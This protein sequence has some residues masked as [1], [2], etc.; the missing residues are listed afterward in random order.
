MAGLNWPGLLKWSIAHSDGTSPSVKE[1]MSAERLQFLEA[2]MKEA[3]GEF[4]DPN[5]V[6]RKAVKTIQEPEATDADVLRSLN[7]IHGC[8]EDAPEISR[9]LDRLGA[10][11]VVVS[12]ISASNSDISETALR[13]LQF[14]LLNNREIQMKA[15]KYGC[16]G[17]VLSNMEENSSARFSVISA[18]VRNEKQ[19]EVDF[20]AQNGREVLLSG[21]S[22]INPKVQVKAASLITHFFEEN[23]CQADADFDTKVWNALGKMIDVS[24]EHP[25]CLYGSQFGETVCA[26]IL[27]MLRLRETFREAFN[28]PLMAD[29]LRNRLQTLSSEGH[30][31]ERSMIDSILQLMTS[32]QLG[33]ASI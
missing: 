10:L 25:S 31:V 15:W 12:K 1:K 21:L 22:S 14:T 23:L 33:V 6:V 16:L 7:I 29:A 3:M 11:E 2:A 19:L 13:I 24:V 18:L 28:L 5:E 8:I 9:D 26:T 30:E 32:Q 20:L 17:L 4:A 27:T